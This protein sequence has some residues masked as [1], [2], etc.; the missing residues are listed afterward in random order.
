MKVVKNQLHIVVRNENRVLDEKY[1]ISA[2]EKKDYDVT[3][4]KKRNAELKRL[5]IL[6]K[7]AEA[8]K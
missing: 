3:Y 5:V 7:L 4:R 8:K 6:G 1:I 2:I